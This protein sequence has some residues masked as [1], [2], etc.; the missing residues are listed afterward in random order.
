MFRI[1]PSIIGGPLNINSNE[2]IINF[3]DNFNTSPK[4]ASKSA[5][6]SG[7][8]NTGYVITIFNG[9]SATNTYDPDLVDQPQTANN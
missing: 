5:N 2:G 9:A 7:S 8:L 1:M 6:G 4:S 3:G